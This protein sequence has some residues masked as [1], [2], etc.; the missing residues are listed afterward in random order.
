MKLTEKELEDFL[1]IPI[2]DLTKMNILN[3]MEHRLKT[4]N[5][6]KAQLELSAN[7]AKHV[8]Y[9]AVISGG[10]IAVATIVGAVLK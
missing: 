6:Y 4:D 10:F 8:I 3:E 7:N 2:E 1:T 9:A 5:F